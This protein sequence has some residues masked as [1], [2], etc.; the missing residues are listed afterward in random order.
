[1][2][3]SSAV[4]AAAL[5]AVASATDYKV[6]VGDDGQNRVSPTV[7]AGHPNCIVQRDA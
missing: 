5:S 3:Y 6:T 2:R 4:A 7:L 1:M